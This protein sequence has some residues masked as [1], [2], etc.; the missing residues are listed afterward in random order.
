MLDNN[1]ENILGHQVHA[2]KNLKHLHSWGKLDDGQVF[3]HIP[4]ILSL[5][6]ENIF[7][8]HIF[9]FTN[10][11]S[12]VTFI[13]KLM[14]SLNELISL[15]LHFHH[16]KIITVTKESF[17]GMNV[18]QGKFLSPRENNVGAD[19][20]TLHAIHIIMYLKV[21][22]RYYVS[23]NVS[24]MEFKYGRNT[25]TLSKF[26]GL[27]CQV[28]L[29]IKSAKIIS[30]AN[31]D[32]IIETLKCSSRL[33]YIIVRGIKVTSIDSSIFSDMKLLWV[34]LLVE[35][36][37]AHKDDNR[38]EESL[39][40]PTKIPELLD[41][42][43]TIEIF[44]SNSGGVASDRFWFNKPEFFYSKLLDGYTVEYLPTAG[45]SHNN[46]VFQIPP[47]LDGANL[48]LNASL[49]LNTDQ[50]RCNGTSKL[51]MERQNMYLFKLFNEFHLECR[52]Q[53]GTKRIF[54]IPVHL[55]NE[56]DNMFLPFLFYPLNLILIF[57][58]VL[59]Y[60]NLW[61]MKYACYLVSQLLYRKEQKII[62]YKFDA[63]IAYYNTEE[64]WVRTRLVPALEQDGGHKYKLCLHYRHFIPG[65]DIADNIVS[66]VQSSRKTI[67]IVTKHY[68]RSGWCKFETK[69]AHTHIIYKNILVESLL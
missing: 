63:F 58:A 9:H 53:N 46:I 28:L 33:E 6:T 22:S 45:S 11:M 57:L 48:T 12:F 30:F 51:Y 25:Y 61:R 56:S 21:I 52:F 27:N 20:A 16:Y 40:S 13:T 67:L 14:S 4:S 23:D 18:R 54:H 1:T 26:K 66:A 69:F 34:K 19:G 59:I 39:F 7:M 36:F 29:I 65:R 32:E 60:K 64:E 37:S 55:P 68:L 24:N 2:S 15:K 3:Q 43:H 42:S 38:N 17:T 44:T 49:N 50:F 41:M 62:D 5:R 35:D 8:E 47:E 10:R 31:F